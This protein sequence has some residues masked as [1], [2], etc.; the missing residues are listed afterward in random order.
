MQTRYS[1][2]R[3]AA[4]EPETDLPAPMIPPNAGFSGNRSLPAPPSPAVLFQVAGEPQVSHDTSPG[5]HG[6]C[7]PRGAIE[8]KVFVFDDF[9]KRRRSRR[10]NLVARGVL[11]VRRSDGE[12]KRNAEI[13]LF[14]KS[15]CLGDTLPECR[16]SGGQAGDRHPEG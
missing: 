5:V 15:S 13:R 1:R 8:L 14:T 9:V 10:A 6:G 12:M 4:C 3:R 2:G 7:A 16:V 11:E